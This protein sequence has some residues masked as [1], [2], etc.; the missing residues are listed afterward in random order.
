MEGK[1]KKIHYQIIY[2]TVQICWPCKP[3]LTQTIPV[4][5]QVCVRSGTLSVIS[6]YTTNPPGPAAYRIYE[7]QLD[8]IFL[9]DIFLYQPIFLSMR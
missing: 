3:S 2:W 6:H 7:A 8:I 1:K 4:K 5:M 9:W